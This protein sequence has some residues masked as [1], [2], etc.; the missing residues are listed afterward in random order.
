MG[1]RVGGTIQG[2]RVC[3]VKELRV[4]GLRRTVQGT[5][6]VPGERNMSR[7]SEAVTHVS[8]WVCASAVQA[9]AGTSVPFA[10]VVFRKGRCP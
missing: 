2:F 5:E 3:G 8:L 1:C 7:F 4:W 9:S 10:S 6:S